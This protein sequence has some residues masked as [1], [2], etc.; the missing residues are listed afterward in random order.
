[1]HYVSRPQRSSSS[2]SSRR[3]Y[4]RIPTYAARTGFGEQDAFWGFVRLHS[5]KGIEAQGQSRL[6]RN[7]HI[8]PTVGWS[9]GLDALKKMKC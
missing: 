2:S 5:V 4:I 9:W 6:E 3:R 1:M 7:D 8:Q